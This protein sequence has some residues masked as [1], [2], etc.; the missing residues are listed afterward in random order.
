MWKVSSNEPYETL[1]EISDPRKAS[2]CIDY[3]IQSRNRNSG[4]QVCENSE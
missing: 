2:F 1:K 4:W 3:S